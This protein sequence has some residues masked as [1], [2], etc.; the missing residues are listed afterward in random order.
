MSLLTVGH[1]LWHIQKYMKRVGIAFFR[2][3]LKAERSIVIV[4][5]KQC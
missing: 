4:D 2:T 1:G 5:A 3:L